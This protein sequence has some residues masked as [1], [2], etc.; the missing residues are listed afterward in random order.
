MAHADDDQVKVHYS[1]SRNINFRSRG[2]GEDLGITWGE[3]REMSPA[4]QGEAL[5]DFVNSIV[6]V[7]VAE[8]EV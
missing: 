3:W 7:T 2:A 5:E 1:S 6:D 4:E 8:D